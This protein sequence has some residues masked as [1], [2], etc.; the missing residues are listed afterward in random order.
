MKIVSIELFNSITHTLFSQSICCIKTKSDGPI[1]SMPIYNNNPNV[2]A[3]T[4]R[5]KEWGNGTFGILG[6]P[7]E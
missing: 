1:Q 3:T 6:G 2:V 7:S 5:P 4:G